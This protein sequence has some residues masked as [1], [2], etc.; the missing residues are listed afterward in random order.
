MGPSA[1][2]CRGR[3]KVYLGRWEG[4]E[5]AGGYPSVPA[6]A[7]G[8]ELRLVGE[9]TGATLKQSYRLAE[10][11]GDS[12]RAEVYLAEDLREQRL[13]VVKIPRLA[14]VHQPDALARF[15]LELGIVRRI[16]HSHVVRVF[17]ADELPGRG[18][19]Y[20]A[21]ERLEGETLESRLRRAGRLSIA[22]TVR[23]VSQV[24]AALSAMHRHSIVH[25]DLRPKKVFVVGE[26]GSTDSVKLLDFGL[27]SVHCGV[28]FPKLDP[29]I[30]AY[31]APELSRPGA[32]ADHR[33]DVFALAVIGYE[34]LTGQH[35]F[36][37]PGAGEE[38][39]PVFRAPLPP[40]SICP[41]VPSAINAVILRALE[42]EPGRRHESVSRFV[43]ALESSA[44]GSTT[45]QRRALGE[46]A[47]SRRASESS[48]AASLLAA[49]AAFLDGR[50]DEAVDL[51]ESLWEHAV[52]GADPEYRRVVSTALSSFHRIFAERIGSLD[53]QIGVGPAG[54][55]LEGSSFT[56]KARELI[57]LADAHISVARLI[58]ASGIPLRD[59]ERMI[60][61]LL[62]RR[63]LVTF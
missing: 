3:L 49:R 37:S 4:I 19:P 31:Q 38:V 61:G 25:R 53:A 44:A 57:A 29:T 27:S 55:D 58:A 5:V 48:V 7:G 6:P 42:Q 10:R 20:L 51:A 45:R 26:P 28:D 52:L 1:L 24:G 11:I 46:S 17:D 30:R 8:T 36:F 35:P 43:S 40:S 63:A 15:K 50:L 21:M 33:V 41:E 56:P 2:C 14:R 54:R 60:A 23:I 22:D 39:H 47:S 59:A 16:A 32:V 12:P 62:R 13:V 9:H 18:R 34:L